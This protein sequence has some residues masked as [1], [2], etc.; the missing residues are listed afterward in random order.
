MYKILLI[1]AQPSGLADLAQGLE[2]SGQAAL[3]WAESAAQALELAGRQG[4]AP[5]LAVI[6]GQGL[7]MDSLALVGRLLEKNALINTAVVSTMEEEEFHEAS[8][9]LGIMTSLPPQPAADLAPALLKKL[10]Q[11]VILPK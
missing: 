5:H 8:E 6:N 11:L 3:T 7:D 2:K 4:Q 9:G 10:S 1:S